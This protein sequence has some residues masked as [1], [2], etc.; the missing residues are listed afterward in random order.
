MHELEELSR[1]CV[2]NDVLIVSDEI[3]SDLVLYGNKHIPTASLSPEVARNTITCLSTSKT[4]NTA[5]LNTSFVIISNPRHR[6]RYKDK[7][8]DF[9]LNIGNIAG[10]AALEA[11][12]RKGRPWLHQLVKYI[13]EN[14][15]FLEH[16]IQQNIPEIK[17]MKPEAT[18]LVWLDFRETHVDNKKLNEFIIQEAGLGLSDGA[19]FGEEGIG[20][21]RLNI[22]CPRSV[23]QKGLENLRQAYFK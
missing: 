1:I 4:F 2:E 22:G 14:I 18:Y 5:G 11:A 9:H 6:K 10:I 16:Y 3:H 17:V 21:Q 19:L 7:L 15:D 12:Y 20:Y 8:S 13:E 23:L